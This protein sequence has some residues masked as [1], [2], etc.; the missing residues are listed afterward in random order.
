LVKQGKK[1]KKGGKVQGDKLQNLDASSKDRKKSRSDK[2]KKIVWK[3][4]ESI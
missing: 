1:R 3:E 2:K 4:R